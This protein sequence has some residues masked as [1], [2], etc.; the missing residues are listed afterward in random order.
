MMLIICAW[1]Y[2][3]GITGYPSLRQML[4]FGVKVNFI[5][6][7]MFLNLFKC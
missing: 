7:V 1:I 3:L 6:S 2:F 4:S 5:V